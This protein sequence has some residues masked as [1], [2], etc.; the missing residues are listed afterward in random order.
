MSLT[1]QRQHFISC[2]TKSTT[3][4]LHCRCCTAKGIH[5]GFRPDLVQAVLAELR[6][7]AI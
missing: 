6:S 1:S 5:A 7:S 2:C 3:I 4:K